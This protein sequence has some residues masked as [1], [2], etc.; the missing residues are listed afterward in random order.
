GGENFVSRD[1]AYIGQSNNLGVNLDSRDS[2]V[3]NS[4]L[5][6]GADFEE[7]PTATRFIMVSSTQNDGSL[8]DSY[9]YEKHV[10]Y[11]FEGERTDIGQARGI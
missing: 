11:G 6:S 7:T 2:R 1:E 8:S 3:R 9:V 10:K 4:A 5:G